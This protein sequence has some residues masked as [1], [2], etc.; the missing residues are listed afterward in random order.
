MRR[1]VIQMAATLKPTG[2]VARS[3]YAAGALEDYDPK[4]TIFFY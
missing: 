3:C 4:Y 2:T 1:P